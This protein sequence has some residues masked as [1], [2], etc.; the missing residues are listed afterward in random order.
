MLTG[1]ESSQNIN[2][3]DNNIYQRNYSTCAIRCQEIVLRDFGIQIPE[4]ELARYAGEKGWY[5]G[6]GTKMKNIGNILEECGVHVHSSVNNTVSD[7]MHELKAGHRV[8]VCVDSKELYAEPGSK[9]WEFFN[10]INH[11]DHAL[12]VAGLKIDSFNHDNDVV[13]LTDPGKGNA[14]IEY[15]LGHF[16]DA[17]GDARCFMM[18][19]NE[20]APYQYNEI[21]H[22][23]ETSNFA[24]DFIL[25]EFPF[26]NEFDSIYDL[27]SHD[28]CMKLMETDSY[29]IPTDYE[30][31]EHQYE[32]GINSFC[33]DDEY[34]D[35]SD[36]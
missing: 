12:I 34:P 19:T 35:L 20:A 24:S 36:N 2:T 8:I 28:E 22:T 23:M 11:P 5:S 31:I 10:N 13:I 15:P 29:L 26:H 16:E 32:V 17:W 1:H 30:N 18:A 33:T 14:Y 4:D 25:K 9:E 27:S 21:L 7:L 3:F 6:T